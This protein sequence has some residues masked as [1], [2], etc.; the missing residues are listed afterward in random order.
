MKKSDTLL[1]IVLIA[2]CCAGIYLVVPRY[3][4]KKQLQKTLAELRQRITEQE[5]ETRRLRRE[6]SRLRTDPEA[7]ER[8]A[9]EKFG[10][11][12]EGEKIYHFDS[13]PQTGTAT[14]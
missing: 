1:A 4:E 5:R 9:R 11:C 2:V 3:A 6:I 14:E 8:V 10:W 12:A 7:I 13:Q